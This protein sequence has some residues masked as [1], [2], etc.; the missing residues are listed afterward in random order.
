MPCPQC[1]KLRKLYCY[2]CLVPVGT[3]AAEYPPVRLPLKMDMYVRMRAL[4]SRHEQLT[5]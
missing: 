3:T 4:L 2:T 1:E 5:W